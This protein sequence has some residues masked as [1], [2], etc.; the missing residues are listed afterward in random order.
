MVLASREY[1]TW[2]IAAAESLRGM[3]G[4]PTDLAAPSHPERIRNAKGWF[5]ERMSMRY[6]PTIHQL[7]YTAAFDLD[8]ASTNASFRRF[9]E[10]VRSLLEEAGDE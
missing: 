3:H 4:L 7:E 5:S 8:A 10:R 2:L 1:E 9:R 6:D